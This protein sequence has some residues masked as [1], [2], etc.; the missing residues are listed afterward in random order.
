MKRKFTL[1]LAAVMTAATASL[2]VSCK[3]TDEDLYNDLRLQQ[4]QDNQS[5]RDALDAQQ[6]NVEEQ[7]K[8]YQQM[9]D[10]INS[11]TCDSAALAG[12]LKALNDAIDALKDGKAD[13][14]TLTALTQTVTDLTNNYNATAGDVA[15]LKTAKETMQAAIDSLKEA[16]KTASQCTPYDDSKI[17]EPLSTL[18]KAM[19]EAKALAQ[20]A[21]DRLDAVGTRLA[22]DSLAI[23]KLKGDLS[24]LKNTV[25]GNTENI[26]NLSNAVNDLEQRVQN[27]TDA[28]QNLIQ[29]TDNLSQSVDAINIRLV[30]MGDS[31]QSAYT[32]AAE[33]NALAIADSIRIDALQG[34][35]DANTDAIDKLTASVNDLEERVQNNTDAIHN[36]IIAVNN[37]NKKVDNMKAELTQAIADKAAE[38]IQY[39]DEALQKAKDYADQ[40]V[41]AA[42]QELTDLVDTKVAELRTEVQAADKELQDQID[43][44]K[45]D[46]QSLKNDIDTINQKLAD[47]TEELKA[48]QE[49][50]AKQVTG[51]TVQGCWNPAFGMVNTPVGVNTHMLIAYYGDAS[52]NI[53]FPTTASAAYAYPAEALTEKEM[54]MI[55]GT[56]TVTYHTGD[57]LISDEA[58]NAGKVYLTVNPS[59]ADFTGL[60]INLENSQAKASGV[61]L[62]TL[63]RSDKTLEFGYTRAANN[64]FY[65][66]DARVADPNRVQKIDINKKALASDIKD[67]I[68]NRQ[69][70]NLSKMASDLYQLIGQDLRADQNGV[71]CTDAD[72]R[73]VYSQY[74]ILATAAKPLSFTS[75]DF[76]RETIPGYQRMM[77]LIDKLRSKIT[78]MPIF[79][80]GMEQFSH[81]EYVGMKVEKVDTII[82]DPN[83]KLPQGAQIVIRVT[84]NNVDKDGNMTD[85]VEQKIIEVPYDDVYYAIF[86]NIDYVRTGIEMQVQ[87][88]VEFLYDATK[89]VTD[90]L[91][92]V[93]DKAIDILNRVNS[94]GVKIINGVNEK[95]QPVLVYSSVDGSNKGGLVPAGRTNAPVMKAGFILRPTTWTYELAAPVFKKHVA[96]VNAWDASGNSA[97]DGNAA[98]LAALQQANTGMNKV[99]DGN[100]RRV[101]TSKMKAGYTYEIAYSALD[102]SGRVGIYR[103]YVTIK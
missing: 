53:T 1:L 63:R 58:D 49:K 71:A 37:L 64:A 86:G 52:A 12:Q 94:L 44:L 96:V 17:L 27:N 32:T 89:A 80:D 3:D 4:I 25:D 46:V 11:C 95:L 26:K 7:L 5:L 28:I 66:A 40:E 62:G 20:T 36:L 50:M 55:S 56:E 14:T 33:A 42:K 18:E 79:Q 48:L 45:T 57:R 67:L 2:F 85:G 38:L 59:T 90:M 100:C 99:I 65:E 29:A 10:A 77:N 91:D 84:L 13:K 34:L 87:D 15:D 81:I 41:A 19:V 88:I 70:A 8:A 75:L 102:Y 54:Q 98:C 83:S 76:N 101:D 61:T 51:I 74:S 68:Q 23:D 35:V 39:T 73:T 9:L 16:L 31:L 47:L 97:Q 93:T 6:K 78:G 24:S 103:G 43:A 92:L 30:T 22:N 21:N 69:D 72:G 82:T 60:A